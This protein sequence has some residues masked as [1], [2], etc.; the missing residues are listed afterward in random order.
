MD[1]NAKG[2]SWP[3]NGSR[4]ELIKYNIIIGIAN[5]FIETN[6]TKES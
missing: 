4:S 2:I 3:I 1:L 5:L 6:N